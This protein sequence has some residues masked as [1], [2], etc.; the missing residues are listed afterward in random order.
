MRGLKWRFRLEARPGLQSDNFGLSCILVLTRPSN[1]KIPQG[2]VSGFL[3][4]FMHLTDYMLL[5]RF[6]VKLLFLSNANIFK[7]MKELAL[8]V[9]LETGKIFLDTLQFSI[10]HLGMTRKA[11]MA[12][13]VNV[14][15]VAITAMQLLKIQIEE[16]LKLEAKVGCLLAID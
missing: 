5:K 11:E 16:S 10:L 7:M 13:Q 14:I 9:I 4:F 12:E 8:K 3:I 15:D 1:Q 2:F 6:P